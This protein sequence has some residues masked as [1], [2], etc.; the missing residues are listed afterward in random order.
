[1]PLS[2][3]ARLLREAKRMVKSEKISDFLNSP[4][5][6][7]RRRRMGYY[8]DRLVQVHRWL[9]NDEQQAINEYYGVQ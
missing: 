6:F 7:F 5:E 9:V 1:M 2:T 8:S 4:R 3:K